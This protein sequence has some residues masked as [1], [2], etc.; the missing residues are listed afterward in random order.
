M[1]NF[2][3]Q[4]RALGMWRLVALVGTAMLVL[5]LMVWLVVRASQPIMG[6]LY[7][8]LEQRDAGQVIAALDRAKVPYRVEG[9]GTRIMVPDDQVGRVRLSR[10]VRRVRAAARSRGGR[11]GVCAVRLGEPLSLRIYVDVCICLYRS[12]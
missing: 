11:L 3:A 6:L 2:V 8:D 12:I 9:N 5:G 7:A 1:G 10:A 4:L